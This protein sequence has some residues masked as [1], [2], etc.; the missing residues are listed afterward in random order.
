VLAVSDRVAVNC[1]NITYVVNA[2]S[3]KVLWLDKKSYLLSKSLIATDGIL[4]VPFD[5]GT[6]ARE[7][8]GGR[9]LW[10]HPTIHYGD[11]AAVFQ[12][13]FL[14]L[15]RGRLHALNPKDGAVVWSHLT[16]SR[17]RSGGSQYGA[18]LNDTLIV[19]G[20]T[21]FG[22]FDK[23][24]TELWQGPDEAAID[25]P[26][27]TDGKTL[28]CSDGKR[29]LRYV[30]SEEK[31]LP[32]DPLSLRMIAEGLVRDFEQLD[33]AEIKQLES[34]GDAAF[35]PLFDAYLKACAA[36]NKN[37]SSEDS[38]DYYSR[39]S[40]LAEVLPK[41]V[42]G[43]R[44]PQLVAAYRRCD[45][46]AI[47][48]DLLVNLLA[49]H[50]SPDQVVPLF[51]ESLQNER[52]TGENG[53]LKY[54]AYSE[55]PDAVKYMIG[56]LK[57]P[58]AKRDRREA[59]YVNLARTGGKAGLD[60][61]LAQR[62]SRTLL[63]P[64][65]QRLEL[66][67]VGS[68]GK[69][70]SHFEEY[71]RLTQSNLVEERTDDQGRT[72]GLLQSSILGSHGDLW[73]ARKVDG[74]WVEPR[75]SG[76]SV[77]GVTSWAKPKPPEPTVGGK[78]GRELAQGAWF[79]VLPGNPDL[80][81][82]SDGDGLTDVAEQRLGTD[83]HNKDTDGDGDPDDIDPWPNAPF[84]KLSDAEEVLAVA[85]EARYHFAD[86]ESPAIFFAEEGMKPFEMV[87]WAGPVI[88]RSARKDENWSLPL[89]WC[90]QQGVGFLRF[91]TVSEGKEWTEK[92]IRWNGDH[93]EAYVLIST[94]Y[95][96]LEG[97]GYG[98]KLRKIEEQWVV[99]WM[100]MEYIS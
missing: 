64:L 30:H 25:R 13:R 41:V 63:R 59:A 80:Q 45:A 92:I 47:E 32:R 71:R 82:D 76:V 37:H 38:S 58:N 11:F 81:R 52:G 28:V 99:V 88:W 22:W 24:G 1:G 51:L 16:G 94:Y 2:K 83:P 6:V 68:K 48:E 55:H 98:I 75:F 53:L 73:I 35:E 42:T 93:T 12:R 66:D 4:L 70:L 57:D 27:W 40:D 96:G 69:D 90:Y 67:K 17:D 84:R 23:T 56:Q 89:E 61:V 19:R 14:V 9:K 29:L 72:W 21:L 65:E 5:E 100:E 60:A 46:Q 78:T 49:T 7:L 36:Y 62:R 34:L 74:H 43:R 18:I 77:Q 85:F 3:G 10:N 95:G 20:M 50:G 79:N 97:T 39:C 26:I 87:G 33:A 31:E 8:N 86:S 44:T 54:I 91:G 15:D